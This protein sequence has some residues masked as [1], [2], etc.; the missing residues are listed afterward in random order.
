M[1]TWRDTAGEQMP[2]PRHRPRIRHAW[3][4]VVK[5][6]L[7]VLVFVFCFCESFFLCT[8]MLIQ[9]IDRDSKGSFLAFTR[10]A[11]LR[12][13]GE[14]RAGGLLGRRSGVGDALAGVAKATAE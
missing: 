7:F 4:E 6:I 10:T 2:V 11:F 14:S 9:K 8:V 5:L 1:S 13:V 12:S 3:R